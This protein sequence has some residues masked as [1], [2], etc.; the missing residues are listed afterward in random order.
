[1]TR[2]PD[3][4]LST[5]FI[6]ILT[7][8]ERLDEAHEVGGLAGAQDLTQ[9]PDVVLCEAERL[10]LGQFLGF[11]VTRDDLSQTLQSVVQSVHAIPFPG[12]SFHPTN[13]KPAE[14]CSGFSVSPVTS[15]CM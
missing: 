8:A 15:N 4:R 12:V 6:L 5:A 9:G 13:L 11:G 1:M 14:T 3:S 10:D 2:N 7:F